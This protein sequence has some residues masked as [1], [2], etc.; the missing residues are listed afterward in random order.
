MNERV[1]VVD[2]LRGF[3][4]LGILIANMLIF[5]FGLYGKDELDLYDVSQFDHVAHNIL[6]VFVETSFMPIF[7]FLFGYGMIR[8]KESLERRDLKVKRHFSRRFV[9]L[10]LLGF[11]HGAFLWEGD[12]LLA[13]GMTGFLLLL[14]MNR[15]KKTLMI[16]GVTLL[17]LTSL[18]GYGSNELAVTDQEIER[19]NEYVLQ[20]IDVYGS[21]TY[22]EILDQRMNEDPLILPDEAYLIL[23]VLAPLFTLPF[24]LIGM[25]AAKAEWFRNIHH[26]KKLWLKRGLRFSTVGLVLKGMIVF[27]PEFN[28]SGIAY[29]LGG[30]ILALGYIFLFSFFL[31][32]TNAW[33]FKG[34]EAVGKLSL[35]NYLAQTLVCTTLFYGYGLGLFGKGSVLLGFS[36]ALVIYSLQAVISYMWLKQFRTGMFEKGLRMWTYWTLSGR[37]RKKKA[38]HEKGLHERVM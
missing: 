25:Y 3:S 37:P 22:G 1:R 4:L 31:E 13:Y 5:Q 8:M 23:L 29:S 34:F 21:G 19:M 35:S 38:E 14:F 15:K 2:A 30:G 9:L 32:N 7:A 18:L 10:V 6:K 20:T 17:V 24:F 36:L 12:I 33:A 28:G 26:H 27:L 16:W 11:L